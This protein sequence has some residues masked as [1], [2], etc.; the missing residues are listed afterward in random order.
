[1]N[2]GKPAL[3]KNLTLHYKDLDDWL[4]LGP[5]NNYTILDYGNGTYFMSFVAD[6]SS[7]TIEVSVHASDQR[8]IH[9][10]ANATC[11]E[12]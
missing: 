12:T 10:Q 5:Q 9:V 1:L 3:A 11:P 6:I 7:N 8:H 4:T 2:E